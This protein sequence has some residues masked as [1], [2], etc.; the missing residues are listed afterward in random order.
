MLLGAQAATSADYNTVIN[1]GSINVSGN[2]LTNLIAGIALDGNLG[3]ASY[4]TI[5][6]SQTGVIN[7]SGGATGIILYGYQGKASNN[8][9]T[10]CGS[11]IATG[12]GDAI[13]IQ[14]TVIPACD[15]LGCHPDQ[16]EQ[17]RD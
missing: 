1:N 4:N 16:Y 9:I 13:R 15:P 5:T 7:A 8:T 11:I 3:D 12:G 2:G 10:N 17:Q 14:S 6:N